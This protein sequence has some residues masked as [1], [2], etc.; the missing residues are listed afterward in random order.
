[1]ELPNRNQI[2]PQNSVKHNSYS[3]SHTWKK[4]PRETLIPYSEYKPEIHKC[5]ECGK[6]FRSA[7]TLRIHKEGHEEDR[8]EEEEA[9]K[10]RDDE[11]KRKESSVDKRNEFN[12]FL[13]DAS[14]VA[15]MAKFQTSVADDDSGKP[16]VDRLL[17]Y[18]N[19]F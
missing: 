7:N 3:I 19:L 12:S 18:F 13:R 17:A 14:E 15:K 5:D 11:K 9:K 10:R 8:R 4:V 16:E 1:M 2:H 6:E